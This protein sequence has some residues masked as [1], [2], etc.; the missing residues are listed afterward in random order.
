MR[1]TTGLF[2]AFILGACHGKDEG[3]PLPA[4]G[5]VEP[6]ELTWAG[7]GLA[8]SMPSVVRFD[9]A[10]H[11]YYTHQAGSI[12][13]IYH[14]ISEDGL[15]FEDPSG[16]KLVSELVATASDEVSSGVAYSSGSRVH[17]LCNAVIDGTSQLWHATS[18]DGDAFTLAD[19]PTFSEDTYGAVVQATGAS[20]AAAEVLGAFSVAEEGAGGTPSVSLS[21]STNSGDSWPDPAVGF[22]PDDLP[23]PWTSSTVGAGGIWGATIADDPEGGYHM[24]FLGAGPNGEEALGIGQAWSG[25][26]ETWSGDGELWYQPD[27]GMTINGLSLVEKDGSWILWF[28]MAATGEEAA[29]TG[30]LYRMSVE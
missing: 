10:W 1:T 5:E 2:S 26:G 20:Y 13:A 14:A 16:R 19:A 24:L 4:A 22:S 23:T 3:T 28:G 6:V 12:V 29:S 17:L 21:L 25:D 15:S 8:A 30:A 7:E 11:L 9:S 27:D 18:T